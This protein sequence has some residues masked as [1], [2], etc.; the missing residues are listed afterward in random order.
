MIVFFFKTWSAASRA[1]LGGIILASIAVDVE[2][3]DSNM[4]KDM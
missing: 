1:V 4:N 2:E 3:I